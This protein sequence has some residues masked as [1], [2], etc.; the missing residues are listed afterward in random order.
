MYTNLIR[1]FR[2]LNISYIN[3]V[4]AGTHKIIPE[5]EKWLTEIKNLS[6]ARVVNV[7]VLCVV[8]EK[9][10]KWIPRQYIST[11]IIHCF[12]CGDGIKDCAAPRVH[13]ED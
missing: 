13:I 1:L 11:M 8:L 12:E 9:V 2:K 3:R 7:M 10:L 5:G 4:G 6:F